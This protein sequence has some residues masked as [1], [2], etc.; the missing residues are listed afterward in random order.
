MFSILLLVLLPFLILVFIGQRGWAFLLDL[1]R[2]TMICFWVAVI[3]C[4]ISGVLVAYS[5]HIEGSTQ[6]SAKL[7]KV[8][9]NIGPNGIRLAALVG[10]FFAI[11]A[12]A[13]TRNERSQSAYNNVLRRDG[14]QQVRVLIR[15]VAINDTHLIILYPL[16]AFLIFSIAMP[17]GLLV[18]VHK[19]WPSKGFGG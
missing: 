5:L 13:S 15:G 4:F 18:F 10:N 11:R 2:T 17:L 6:C 12:F 9:P 1:Q 16:F 7:L 14:L 3:C 8:Y 19:I